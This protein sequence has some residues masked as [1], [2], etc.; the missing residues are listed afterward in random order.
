M[1]TSTGIWLRRESGVTEQRTPLVP[2]DAAELVAAGTRVTVEESGN[3]VFPAAAYEAA[4]CRV[5]P[6]DTWPDA[7]PDDIVLGLKE[8]SPASFA[9]SHRHVFFGHA[10]KGQDGGPALLR[11][12]AAGRG[13]LLDLE[14]LTD[15]TGRRVVAFGYWAGYAGAALAVLHHRGLLA[16]PLASWTRPE[17]DGRLRGRATGATRALVVGALGRSGRGAREALAVAGVAATAWDVA[18]TRDLDREALLG[19]DL[20]VN[21]VLASEP[22][23]P[24]LTGADFGHPGRRLSVVSDVSCDVTSACNRLPVYRRVTDWAEP[25]RR[26]AAAPPLDLIAI[27]NLPSL[28]PRESSAAFS[29]DLLP[30]VTDL[31]AG[32][33]AVWGRCEQHFH[34]ALRTM[35][36]DK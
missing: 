28:L 21:A 10:Y 32:R 11:R 2:G 7:P 20:L 1:T 19:H 6:A 33:G 35:T 31:L 14:Y 26:L 24:F 16:A 22:G 17:L 3:R 13:T 30:R 25:V 12:F 29:R 18:E 27:D 8:P 15:A 9:L 34:H 5:V 36:S 23:T 4:G